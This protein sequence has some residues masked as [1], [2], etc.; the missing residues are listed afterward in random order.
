MTAQTPNK[1][2]VYIDVDEE[3]TGIIDKVRTGK[4]SIVALVLPKRAAVFQSV[5]NMKLLKRAADQDGKK[6]VLITSEP[7]ILPLAGTVGLHVAANL[8]SKPY[9]PT[10][11]DADDDASA[12]DEEPVELDPST[13]IGAV[14]PPVG[15]EDIQ[16]DNTPKAA[17]P[18]A[19]SAAKAAKGK[20]SSKLRVPDF[21]KFRTLLIAGGILLVLLV[22]F[23]YWAFAIAPKAKVVLRGETNDASLAFDIIA[24]T[25]ATSL[26][27]EQ[28][29]VPAKIKEIKKTE[30]EKVPATGQKDRGTKATG[31]VKIYNCS[32]ADKLGDT[33]RTIPAGTGISSGNL[34][35]ILASSV[36]VEPSGFTG[37]TCKKDKESDATV[38][39]AQNA[40]DQYNL[41]ARTYSVSGF[42]SMSATGSAMTGGTTQIVKVV[43]AADVENAKQ[44]LAS[45]QVGVTEELKAGLD[46]EGYVGLAETFAANTPTF[47]PSPSIDSEAN[48]VTVTA[49]TTYT[50]MGLKDDDLKKLVEKEADKEDSID[51]SKQTILSDGLNSATYQLGAKKTTRTNIN[52]QTKVVAGPQID[53]EAIKKEIMG[54][55]RGEAEQLLKARPGIKEAR[56]ETS[57]FWSYAVPKKASKI[58]FI[59][60]E[61]N[62]SQITN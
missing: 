22:L 44:K 23:S 33:E 21:K 28:S 49:E 6:V 38:V 54:K 45:K 15:E 7:G 11:P 36:T 59:V 53:Q 1:S 60:E 4:S 32:K 39:N 9:L 25:A 20:K 61:A 29:I 14:A 57:P 24:D 55:K 26:N 17:V 56:I 30:S 52:V 3:I 46:A 19:A 2:T 10:I 50:M 62:G 27:E 58:T 13:P 8:N 43:S 42:S 12:A 40:G 5:V 41:S 34:T 35:F 37:D 18:V 48:E 51:M 31:T 47:N 16:I